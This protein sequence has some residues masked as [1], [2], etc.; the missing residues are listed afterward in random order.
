MKVQS[1]PQ[2]KGEA[3]NYSVDFNVFTGRFSTSVSSVTWSVDSGSATITGEATAS[4]VSSALIATDNT[5]CAMIKVVA[6]MANTEI[7]IHFFKIDVNDPKC[8]PQ[9]NR[10]HS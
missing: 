10:Y 3:F 2:Y 8:S 7:D 6:T 5:G 1:W 9:T 4:N